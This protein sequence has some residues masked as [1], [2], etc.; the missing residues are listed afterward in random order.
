MVCQLPRILRQYLKSG[1]QL[2]PKGQSSQGM[3]VLV[4]AGFHLT[5]NVC[6]SE[7]FRSVLGMIIDKMESTKPKQYKTKQSIAETMVFTTYGS[8]VTCWVSK[9]MYSSWKIE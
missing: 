6:I 5:S 1:F 8:I 9:R 3:V 7:T 2:T 4:F